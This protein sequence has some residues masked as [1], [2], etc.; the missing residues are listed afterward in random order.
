MLFNSNGIIAY[1]FYFTPEASLPI[2][3]SDSSRGGEAK[4]TIYRWYNR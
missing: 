2:I 1:V 3:G 4:S